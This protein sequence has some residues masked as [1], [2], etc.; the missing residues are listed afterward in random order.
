[1]NSNRSSKLTLRDA[2]FPIVF[3][4]LGVVWFFS[5]MLVM[6]DT[7]GLMGHKFE[8]PIPLYLHPVAWSFAII[9]WIYM[10]VYKR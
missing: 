1:M 5:V 7:G 2:L 8:S 6:T 10:E 3:L 4:T 9:G